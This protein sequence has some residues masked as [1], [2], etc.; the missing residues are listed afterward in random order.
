MLLWNAPSNPIQTWYILFCLASLMTIH[1]LMVYNSMLTKYSL[2]CSMQVILGE[3]VAASKLTLFEITKQIS[4]A[5]Q[6]RAEQGLNYLNCLFTCLHFLTIC[7]DLE[8]HSYVLVRQI[9]RSNPPARR[10][11]REHPW[12]VCTLEGTQERNIF[13]LL[14]VKVFIHRYYVSSCHRRLLDMMLAIINSVFCL[15]WIW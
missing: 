12:S 10:V 1:D 7:L 2:L 9:P 13:K 4:D 15:V 3:E 14:L 8:L 6:A 11:D 5:I